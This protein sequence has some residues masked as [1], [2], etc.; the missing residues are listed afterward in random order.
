MTRSSYHHAFEHWLD[1][2]LPVTFLVSAH[3]R[4]LGVLQGS[5]LGSSW[6]LEK[7]ASSDR[8]GEDAPTI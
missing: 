4:V 5:S 1:G 8:L 2:H 3:A 7:Y 6:H